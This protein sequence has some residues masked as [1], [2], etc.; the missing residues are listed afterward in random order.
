M[1]KYIAL[2]NSDMLNSNSVIDAEILHEEFALFGNELDKYCKLKE[3]IRT[4]TI[5]AATKKNI[6]R[7]KQKKSAERG[8][9]KNLLNKTV[10]IK[11]QEYYKTT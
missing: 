5:Q 11:S 2:C 9:L 1:Q 3:R 8:E 10:N 6:Y 4:K 7:I